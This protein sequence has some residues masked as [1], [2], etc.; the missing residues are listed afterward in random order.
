[1]SKIQ[2]PAKALGVPCSVVVTMLRMLIWSS[3][4]EGYHSTIVRL[5]RDTSLQNLAAKFIMDRTILLD[6][7]IIPSATNFRQI[8]LQQIDHTQR[9]YFVYLHT[10][11]SYEAAM[12]NKVESQLRWEYGGKRAESQGFGPVLL[13]GHC[14]RAGRLMKCLAPVSLQDSWYLKLLRRLMLHGSESKLFVGRP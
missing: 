4:F 9:M 1:M 14:R 12:S 6:A 7:T 11:L 2:Q 8:M 3:C 5:G 13:G 10:P